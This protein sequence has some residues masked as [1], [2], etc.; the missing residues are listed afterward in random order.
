VLAVLQA[1]AASRPLLIAIDDV[2][3]MDSMSWALAAR[4]HRQLQPA[5]LVL[6]RRPER[7][8]PVADEAGSLRDIERID[9]RPLVREETEVLVR[10]VLGV[11]RV[12]RNL[13]GLIQQR[14][15][16]NPLFASELARAMRDDGRVRTDP[17]RARLSETPGGERILPETV[18]AVIAERIDRLPAAQQLT[19]KV[20]AVAGTDFDVAMLRDVHPLRGIDIDA[21][22]AAFVRDDL[23]VPGAGGRHA[24]RHELI[25]QAAYSMLSFAD[26][27]KLHRDVAGWLQARGAESALLAHH[28]AEADVP[29]EALV[30][31]HRAG[32]AAA[33][34]FANR[35]A[36]ELLEQALAL[37]D[38]GVPEPAGLRAECERL[39]GYVQLWSGRLMDSR[40]HLENSLGLLG[41]RLPRSRNAMLAR[42]GWEL[43]LRLGRSVVPSRRLRPLAG[44]DRVAALMLL[45][46]G[47]IGYFL[48]DPALMLYTSLRC[49]RLVDRGEDCAETAL[50]YGA[51]AAGI[52][53]VPL[54]RVSSAYA[55]KALRIAPACG[56]TAVASQVMLFTAMYAAGIGDW[57]AAGE[58][59]EQGKALSRRAGDNRRW[60]ECMVVD[61]YLHF[62]TGQY[63]IAHGRFQAAANGGRMRGDRQA[64]AWGLVGMSRVR[65]REA[66]F[67]EAHEH[68]REAADLAADR[69][70]RVELQGQL[71][72]V[73][74]QRG[75]PGQALVAARE[76]LA[77]AA[78]VRP[79]SFSTLTGLDAIAGTLLD[80]WALARARRLACDP[81]ALHRDLR[82]A[83]RVLRRFAGIFPIGRPAALLQEARYRAM[84]GHAALATRRAR[85]AAAAAERLRMPHE[86]TQAALA[87]AAARANKADGARS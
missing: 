56:D 22:V 85:E 59:I 78:A 66:R 26:R 68:L 31:L 63:A 6:A 7:S 25:R 77:L 84:R 69:L 48:E 33:E 74:L 71:A 51:L 64:T 57:H 10:D 16:G 34:R 76:A 18:E 5:L 1:L 43:A 38:R 83:L 60:D 55:Q 35:E 4:A 9:V 14:A 52:G 73:H 24:F 36:G 8:S 37:L 86:A 65:L 12:D 70:S 27:R 2:H 39:L 62:H 87:L 75:Q 50:V 79:T 42:S 20:A 72:L 11:A 30:H 47:H 46:L 41:L 13:L 58:R 45:R 81:H 21:Q 80:L 82:S 17:S 49:M 19:L 44:H 3:W 29:H 40:L 32:A 54:H 15:E 67:E 61:G 23:V 28:W 53:S